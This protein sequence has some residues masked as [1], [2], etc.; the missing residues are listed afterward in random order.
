MLNET[1]ADGTQDN[2]TYNAKQQ[3][4]SETLPGE[5]INNTYDAA[6]DLLSSTAADTLTETTVADTSTYDSTGRLSSV[7]QTTTGA[8]P[9]SATNDFAYTPQGNIASE[10]QT[11]GVTTEYAYYGDSVAVP[12]AL[13]SVT[14]VQNGATLSETDYT[15]NSAQQLTSITVNGQTF[16][17]GYQ[18]GTNL[19]GSI[20]SGS[21][22]TNFTYDSDTANLTGISAT[23]SGGSVYSASYTYNLNNQRTAASVTQTNSDGS[24]TST[25]LSYSYDSANELSGVSGTAAT[26]SDSVERWLRPTV[27]TDR[28]AAPARL[29]G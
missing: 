25:D 13:E 29:W 2:Y 1:Y 24:A 27:T 26:G 16:S 8:T 23:G 4:V 15:Y 12:G 6:G 3:L 28:A 11:G 5:T 9:S 22:T 14:L 19:I 21:A 10:T 17:I 18:S 20:A 7:A